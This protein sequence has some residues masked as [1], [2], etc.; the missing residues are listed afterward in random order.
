MRM[1]EENEDKETEQVFSSPK[2]KRTDDE[3]GGNVA[4]QCPY[5]TTSEEEAQSKRT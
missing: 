3:R 4:R 1:T 5:A 2:T